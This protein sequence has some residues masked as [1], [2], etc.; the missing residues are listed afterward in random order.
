[1]NEHFDNPF[2]TAARLS[3][4]RLQMLAFG[5]P[6]R[7]LVIERNLAINRPSQATLSFMKTSERWHAKYAARLRQRVCP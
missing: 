1:M 6:L 2:P 3:A 4:E 5:Y 7:R